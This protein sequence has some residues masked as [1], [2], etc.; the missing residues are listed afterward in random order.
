MAQLAGVPLAAR[1][2]SLLLTTL[3]NTAMWLLMGVSF[4]VLVVANRTPLLD[5]ALLRVAIGVFS[6]SRLAGFLTPFS[7][8]GRRGQGERDGAAV[9]SLFVGGS[10]A[11]TV[12][13]LSR[14]LSLVVEVGLRGWCLAAAA[15]RVDAG[16]PAQTGPAALI[17]SSHQG[18]KGAEL[19]QIAGLGSE[20]KAISR[21]LLNL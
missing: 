2:R 10:Q 11:I 19:R 5:P 14:A 16:R 6:L 21:Y 13:L 4:Y 20:R 7:P 9:D 18:P 12:A 3:L 8:G 15:R 17:A 1:L